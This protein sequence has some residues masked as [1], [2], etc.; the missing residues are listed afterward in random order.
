MFSCFDVYVFWIIYL[1]F[2]HKHVQVEADEELAWSSSM[3]N[4]KMQLRLIDR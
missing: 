3:E 4:N 2:V 1:Q